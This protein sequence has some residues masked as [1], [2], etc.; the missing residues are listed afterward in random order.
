MVLVLQVGHEVDPDPGDG[1]PTPSSLC[2]LAV[3]LPDHPLQDAGADIGSTF[4]AGE[5][6]SSFRVGEVREHFTSRVAEMAGRRN[7]T[8][9]LDVVG[10]QVEALE[11][12]VEIALC[13]CV[14]EEGFKV[15]YR[16]VRCPLAAGP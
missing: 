13:P 6:V 7:T 5:E 12:E 10:Q 9:A 15:G 16:I 3:H 8:V 14:G 2:T 11:C 4:V 1:P